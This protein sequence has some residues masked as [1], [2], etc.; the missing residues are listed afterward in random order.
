M[1]KIHHRITFIF[2]TFLLLSSIGA[3]VTSETNEIVPSEFLASNSTNSE[4]VSANDTTPPQ[5]TLLKPENGLYINNKKIISLQHPRIIGC[6]E[7]QITAQDNETGINQVIIYLDDAL[8]KTF[9]TAPYVFVLNERS[10]GKHT[11]RIEA[12]DNQGNKAIYSTDI[13]NYNLFPNLRYC[14]VRGRVVYGSGVIKLGIPMVNITAISDTVEKSTTT[15]N[16]PL[17][18]RGKFIMQLPPGVYIFTFQK[19]GY[20]IQQK[21]IVV[22]SRIS[23]KLNIELERDE[24]IT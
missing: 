12:F 1:N 17:L 19:T 6:V 22:T 20:K 5:I 24:F 7:I 23:K 21:Q 10:I 16:I 14:I 13:Y 11:I 4:N 2:I 18:N 15:K 3:N 9:S 8:K